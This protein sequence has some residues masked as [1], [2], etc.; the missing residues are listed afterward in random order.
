MNLST[1]REIA[2]LDQCAPFDAELELRWSEFCVKLMLVVYIS[3]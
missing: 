2:K 3:L 1:R